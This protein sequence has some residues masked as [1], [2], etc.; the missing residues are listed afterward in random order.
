MCRRKC[1]GISYIMWFYEK[2]SS[3]IAPHRIIR[4]KHRPVHEGNRA[5]LAIKVSSYLSVIALNDILYH[6]RCCIR[7]FIP[8]ICSNG[9]KKKTLKSIAREMQDSWTKTLKWNSVPE[10]W[11]GRI[12]W[13]FLMVSERYVKLR[14]I[15]WCHVGFRLTTRLAMPYIFA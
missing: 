4:Y 15:L 2:C 14:M 7:M 3:F 9:K 12:W 5:K 10:M 13:S 1:I 11:I 6:L 8:K